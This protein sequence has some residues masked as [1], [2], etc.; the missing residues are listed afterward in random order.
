MRRASPVFD[1]PE[2]PMLPKLARSHRTLPMLPLFEG[3]SSGRL[4]NLKEPSEL[5]TH[6]TAL[7][8]FRLP[9]LNKMLQ[10]TPAPSYSHSRHLV[11]REG[12]KQRRLAKGEAFSTRLT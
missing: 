10:V 5:A 4:L 6:R 12:A 8:H 1:W 2:H 9:K 11:R 7:Q 3:T